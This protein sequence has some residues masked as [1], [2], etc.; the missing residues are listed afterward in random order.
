MHTKTGIHEKFIIMATLFM[1]FC[2]DRCLQ[3]DRSWHYWKYNDR[4][5]RKDR[6]SR[7]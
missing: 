2:K 6:R 3:G 7:L 1:G 5:S 4:K